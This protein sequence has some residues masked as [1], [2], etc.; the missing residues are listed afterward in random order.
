M[1]TSRSIFAALG[2]AALASTFSAACSTP[3][4]AV[5][6]AVVTTACPQAL[7]LDMQRAPTDGVTTLHFN[8][9]GDDLPAS[10]LSQD[11]PFANNGGS[12]PNVPI[13]KNRRITCEARVGS[14]LRARADSGP[15]DVGASGGDVNLTLFLR[16]VDAFV[17]TGNASS[18]A[19]THLITPRAGHQMTQLA[20][21]RV[22][23]TGGYTI[24]ASSVLHY[25]SQA[26]L[27][28]PRDG[29]FENVAGQ[30]AYPRANHL[31]VPV[32][33]SG[34]GGVLLFG[35]EGPSGGGEGPVASF[36]LYQGG[37]FNSLAFPSMDTPRERAAMALDQKTGYPVLAGGANGPDVP[38]NGVTRFDTLTYFNPTLGSITPNPEPLAQAIA[39]AVAVGPKNV[40]AN[41]LQGG[42]VM[43][44]GTDANGNASAQISGLVF[45]DPQHE[46]VPVVDFEHAPLNALPTPRV[47]H[48]AVV[49]GDDTIFVLGGSTVSN[50]SAYTHT[51]A[52]VTVV[53]RGQLIVGNATENLSQARADGCAVLLQTRGSQPAPILY[54]GG[55]TGD[56]SGARSTASVDVIAPSGLSSTV[57]ALQGPTG[58]GNWALQTSR[59]HEACL[60]L[61]DGT[62]LVTGGLQFNGASGTVVT[63]GSA[64]IYTP[65]AQ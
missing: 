45:N 46:Y 62:V 29:T 61:A 8:L 22:L 23:I 63:V 21:G 11:V 24:D 1:R 56:S 9:T 53:N 35:G 40:A 48:S 7:S 55:A 50:D 54:I 27:Y 41:N 4:V 33:V 13:G 15:F 57:R 18:S 25:L 58:G 10:G 38:N 28:N 60:T 34:Q 37:V 47:H 3:V 20:D 6:V 5:N 43:L 39:D 32:A 36:E 30:Q 65:P 49:A 52:A 14:V 64:E 12:I 31:A 19:C 2:A 42:I 17:F 16:V 59:H 44:G 26:E 51:T